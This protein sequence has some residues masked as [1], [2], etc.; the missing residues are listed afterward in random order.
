MNPYKFF[1]AIEYYFL[2]F[3][4]SLHSLLFHS[5]YDFLHVKQKRE[6]QLQDEGEQI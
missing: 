1:F 3:S 5:F 6:P 2:H 4:L